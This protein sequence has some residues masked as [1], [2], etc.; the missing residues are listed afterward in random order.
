MEQ[1]R[2][3]RNCS[4]INSIDNTGRCNNCSSFSGLVLVTRTEANRLILRHRLRFFRSRFV[5]FGLPLGVVI[6][7]VI[8]WLVAFYGLGP[9][10]ASST[11]NVSADLG[12]GTWAQ[13]RRTSENAGFTPDQAPVPRTVKWIY[14]SLGTLSA[15]P[16]ISGDT[17]YL[18]NDAGR[19]V[20]LNRQTAQP[21]WEYS[22]GY[23]S[24]STPAVA[25]GLV[26]LAFRPGLV[27]GVDRAT[28]AERWQ[29]NLGHTIF[30]S[31]V[32]ADGSVYIGAGDSNLHV[33]DIATGEER[34]AFATQDWIVSP[35]A[36]SDGTIVVASQNN[37][38][39]I[40]DAK[41]GRKRLLF[42]TGR[43][44]YGGGPTIQ[45]DRVFTSSD[46]GW[47]WAIDRRAKTYPMERAIFWIKINLFVWQV[48]S[49]PPIQRGSLW[50]KKVGGELR[51]FL[52]VDHDTVYGATR[53][54]KVFA[55]DSATGS[56]RWSTELGTLIST[57]PTVAGDTVLVGTRRGAVIGLAAATGEVLWDFK[58]GHEITDSPI[59][60][61]DT[62]YV[63][64][65]DGKLTA[66]TG[67]R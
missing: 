11:T 33:L 61:G 40:V 30:S 3:C 44:R 31:P 27:V 54:G 24:S 59:V 55:L 6:G 23:P 14:D 39:Y 13:T 64:S 26:I 62:M 65:A 15:S 36:Y 58:V 9:T 48:I 12:P 22:S 38:F 17:I 10:P 29:T 52:A 28:G 49:Q 1:V 35:V 20:A 5:R 63:V 21:V 50:L 16:A 47:V 57:S 43:Q 37:L 25:G 46:R 56:F 67:E 60:V 42:D 7:L 8:W 34:W 45:G 4:H 41:T 18:T 19:T 66:L 53:Q 32:V 51:G 2:A